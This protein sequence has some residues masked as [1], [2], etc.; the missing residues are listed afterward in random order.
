PSYPDMTLGQL[1]DVVAYL[2]GLGGPH[3]PMGRV[4]PLPGWMVQ[5][6]ASDGPLPAPPVDD[7]R[8]YLTMNYAIRDG[9]LD[10]FAAWL[11]DEGIPKFLAFPGVERIDTWVDR[12][13]APA[14]TT[15]IVFRSAADRDRFDRDPTIGQLGLVFD[16]FIG[17]HDHRPFDD[18]PPIFRA[19][20]LSSAAP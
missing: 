13:R 10:A 3:P 17:N 19:A 7:S 4:M 14:L 11:R 6:N 2:Q 20:T 9:R 5:A 8:A 1:A 16:G 12:T 15:A 18:G